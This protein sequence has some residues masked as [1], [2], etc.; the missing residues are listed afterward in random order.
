MIDCRLNLNKNFLELEALL[1]CS[2]EYLVVHY[3]SLIESLISFDHDLS[4]YQTLSSLHIH[5]EK[6][7][8][9][10]TY[11]L[12]I[13]FPYNKFVNLMGAKKKTVPGV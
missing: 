11:K 9:N 8:H 13:V 2:V 10:Q 12:A 6:I 7:G 4:T 3:H 1:T 5:P